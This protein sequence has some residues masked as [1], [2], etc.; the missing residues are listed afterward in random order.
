VEELWQRFVENFI[1]RLDGPL[2]FRFILQPTMA[3]IFAIMSGIKDARTGKTPFLWKFITHREY[4]GELIKDGWQH[5]SKLFI[6]AVVLDIV[7]QWKACDRFYPVETL[8]VAFVLA[9]VPYFLLR[10]PVSRV[11]RMFRK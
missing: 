7:Y 9:I 6:L 2:H 8:L 3:T 10:G 5:V 1:N 4:R 11:V